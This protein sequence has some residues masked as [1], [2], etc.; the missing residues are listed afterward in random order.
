MRLKKRYF[1]GLL[2]GGIIFFGPKAEFE[3]VDGKVASMNI[4]IHQLDQYIEEKESKIKNLKPNNE[5]RIIWADS[6]HKT[7]YA[8]VYL[9]GF[10]A[11]IWEGDALHTEFAKRYGMNLYLARQQD[12]GIADKNTFKNLSPK[13]YLESAKEAVAIG[14][15]IGEK[16]ILMSCSTGGTH[17]LYI[18]ANNPEKVFAQIL[19]SPNIAI[20]NPAAK[21]TTMPWGEHIADALI[22]E[23]VKSGAYGKPEM[24]NFAT[25]EYHTKGI[26]ALESLLEQTMTAETF[27]KI[28][29]P[30][31]IGY[32]YKNEEE[33]DPVVSV[34]AML[35]MH[36]QTQTPT[37]QKRAVPFPNV[38]NHVICSV[39]QSKD[40][41]SVRQE[42]Y[43][44]VEEVLGL[45]PVVKIGS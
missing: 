23:H 26:I 14:Q 22:G 7:A 34:E 17:S 18:T 35:E 8:L 9:H 2:L 5:A 27:R 21:L 38:G 42:T 39:R 3:S 43:R 25:T 30:Y 12:H 40:Y 4:P 29:T 28:N 37:P 32:Y 45:E 36:Q 13:N 33:Q 15:L 11:S 6:V 31:F 1:L 44:F 10:S 41:E 16:V 24:E 19:Y 20:A